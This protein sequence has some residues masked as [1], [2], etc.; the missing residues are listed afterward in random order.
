MDPQSVFCPN[1]H[2]TARGLQGQGTIRIHSYKEGR[3]RCTRCRGTFSATTG[4]TFWRL[5]TPAPVVTTVVTLLAHGCPRQA[6]VAAFGLDERTVAS[7]Q[8]RAGAHCQRVHTHLVQ[9]GQVDLQHVQAD[10]IYARSL[11][12]T[13]RTGTRGRGRERV[14]CPARALRGDGAGVASNGDG[15]ALAPLAW[16]RDQCAPRQAADLVRWPCVSAPARAAQRCW[17]VWTA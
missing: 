17:S 10:E 16:R 9:A 5:R 14:L 11:H 6:I 15:R 13:P 4:T 2:C 3:Y 1:E 7:W 8:Q 12:P